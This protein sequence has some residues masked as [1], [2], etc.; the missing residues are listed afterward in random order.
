MSCRWWHFLHNSAKLK[1]FHILGDRGERFYPDDLEHF[2]ALLEL[3]IG[4]DGSKGGDNC[5]AMVCTPSL[6]SENVLNPKPRN[7][8]KVSAPTLR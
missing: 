5:S 6:F 1:E 4:M 3:M 7:P 2:R 8:R